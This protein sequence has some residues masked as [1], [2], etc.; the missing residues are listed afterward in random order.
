DKTQLTQTAYFKRPEM[1]QANKNIVI[2]QRLVKLAGASLL[3][4]LSVVG[5]GDYNGYTSGASH[6]N[7]TLSAV[8]GIPLYDGGTTK[9]KIREAQSDLR[10]QQVTLS[11]LQENVAVEV[12]QA[13]ANIFDA[14]TRASSAGL[15][16]QQA[17][18]AY[19]LANVR[20]QNGIGTILDVVNAQ[21]QL[22]QARSN[23]LNAQY[24]YQT[25][26]AQLTRAIGGR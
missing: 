22:A 25:S 2:A 9:A 17:E 1:I 26:L 18:E 20:Y 4:S 15:G 5:T 21:A 19:R 11:Q 14:Q 24:D 23:L 8:L 6:D 7:A 3:P 13:L 10:S 12:R 16:A